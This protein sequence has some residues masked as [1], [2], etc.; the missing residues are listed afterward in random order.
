[1]RLRDIYGQLGMADK[2][3]ICFEFSMKYHEYRNIEDYF[4][5]NV[6]G[7]TAIDKHIIGIQLEGRERY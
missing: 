2:I 1:M 5:R 6:Y 4:D 3:H 7:I